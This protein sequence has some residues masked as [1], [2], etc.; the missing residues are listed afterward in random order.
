MNFF[1]I[2]KKFA[3]PALLLGVVM[4]AGTFALMPIY[5]ANTVHNTILQGRTV[6]V[7]ATLHD[8]LEDRDADGAHDEF[9]WVVSDTT[10]LN[11][12]TVHVAVTVELDGDT[13]QNCAADG[14]EVITLEGAGAD[15]LDILV[16]SAGAF[17][18]IFDTEAEVEAGLVAAAGAPVRVIAGSGNNN[19]MC[20]LHFTMNPTGTA[21]DVAIK[22]PTD[23]GLTQTDTSI[24]VTVS[25]FA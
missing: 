22:K 4:I 18:N 23:V 19:V 16:G 7:T 17:T 13:N 24:T 9:T 14:V 3:I 12:R 5:E 10:P 1:S 6:Q 15:E 2:M 11:M 8:V 20:V 21:N 25:A